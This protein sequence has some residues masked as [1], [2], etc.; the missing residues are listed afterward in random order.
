MNSSS[1]EQVPFVVAG[2]KHSGGEVY[3]VVNP[4]DRSVVGKVALANESVADDA[5]QRTLKGFEKTRRLASYERSQALAYV[6]NRI[7]ERKEEF[8]R[9]ITSEVG[10]PIQWSRV[11]VDRAVLTFQ[12]ASEEAKRIEG[13]AIPLDL[14]ANAKGRFGLVRRFP[15]GII[16]CIA[17]FNFPLNLVAHK[18]APAIASGNAFIIKPPPQAPLTSL[19]LGEI[20]EASG[21]PKGAFSILPCTNAVAE[22]LVTDDRIKM[23]SFT[24]SNA[25]GWRLKSKAGKKKVTLELGGNA[26]IIV[27]KTASL[28]ETVRKNVLGSFAYAGQVCIKVQRIF[29]HESIYDSYR[30]KFLDATK[31][32]K[33]GNPEDADTH[34]GPLI[35]DYAAERVERWIVEATQ[36]GA[37][38]LIGGRRKDRVVEPTVLEN[39]PKSANVYCKEIFGPVIT[40]HKFNTIE[41]AVADVNDSSFGLQAGIFSNDYDNIL[42]AYDNIDAGAVIVNDNPTFRIDHMPYGGIKD[43][44]FGREG[45][46]YAIHEMTEPKLLV[47]G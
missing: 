13:E 12:I 22:K 47:M 20:I 14:T 36:L 8:S 31:S 40:L 9:L 29:A 38:V 34:V 6:S 25:V 7:K 21:Y 1:K 4:W 33:V 27:D 16:L 45:V 11:E 10:K 43:S 32:L 46:K 19:M 44:G 37:K 24:G 35:D 23:L 42:Y 41:E 5:V 15:I 28:E 30:V 2:E 39:V 17:P 26:G 18:V 3:A